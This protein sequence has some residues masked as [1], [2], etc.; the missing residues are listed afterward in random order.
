[1][2]EK[3]LKLEDYELLHEHVDVFLEEVARLPSKR[4]IDFY[5]NLVLRESPVSKDSYMMSI[6]EL[7]EIKL[8]L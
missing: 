8:K 5:I 2:K 1:V 3:G 7:M 4:E 6:P